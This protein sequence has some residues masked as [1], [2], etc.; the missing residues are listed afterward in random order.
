MY[1]FGMLLRQLREKSGMTQAQLAEKINRNKTA[2]SKYESNLQFPTLETLIQLAAVFRVSLDY[3]AG[4]DK[5][6]ALSLQGLTGKQEELLVEFAFLVRMK[7][8][9]PETA[10]ADG[11]TSRQLALLNEIMIVFTKK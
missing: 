1:D 4:L 9:H 7:N 2:V 10:G 8:V 6:N 5:R 3:L 11:L